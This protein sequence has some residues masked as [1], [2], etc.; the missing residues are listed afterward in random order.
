MS[1]EGTKKTT[2]Q[3]GREAAELIAKYIFVIWCCRATPDLFRAFVAPK[4]NR[5]PTEVFPPEAI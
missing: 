2:N 1:H 5:T 3:T 4:S